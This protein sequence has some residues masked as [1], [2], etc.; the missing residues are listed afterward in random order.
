MGIVDVH[1]VTNGDELVAE[2]VGKVGAKDVV[3]D[4]VAVLEEGCAE[5]GV[6]AR[7]IRLEMILGNAAAAAAVI[8]FSG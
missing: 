8:D 4:G 1:V 5:G 3:D 6:I 2:G 7:W